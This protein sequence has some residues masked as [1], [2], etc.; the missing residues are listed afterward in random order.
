MQHR[1]IK[2]F[3]HAGGTDGGNGTVR[4]SG[5][6]AD[7]TE[8]SARL[9]HVHVYIV[10]NTENNNYCICIVSPDEWDGTQKKYRRVATNPTIRVHSVFWFAVVKRVLRERS[11]CRLNGSNPVIKSVVCE[12]FENKSSSSR[13]LMNF[14]ER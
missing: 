3:A 12:R 9:T 1:R 5:S 6:G 14:H 8:T 10:I 2:R 7:A 4:R 11:E 13:L